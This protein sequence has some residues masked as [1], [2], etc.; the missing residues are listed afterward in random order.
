MSP[1]CVLGDLRAA[2]VEAPCRSRSAK[3]A[4]SSSTRTVPPSL[5]SVSEIKLWRRCKIVA[6]SLGK[7]G[8]IPRSTV[9]QG[10]LFTFAEQ[11]RDWISFSIRNLTQINIF[12]HVCCASVNSPSLLVEGTGGVL[13]P[14]RGGVTSHRFVQLRFPVWAIQA[15]FMGNELSDPNRPLPRQL[16]SVWS[17]TPVYGSFVLINDCPPFAKGE[18]TP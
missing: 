12:T 17:K 5:T 6:D 9:Q 3:V 2:V 15:R 4:A 11:S 7:G 18:E 1:I 10:L 16:P 8:H 14:P 13:A